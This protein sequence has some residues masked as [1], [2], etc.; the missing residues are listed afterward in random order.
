MTAFRPVSE[1][2][3]SW[4][5]DNVDLIIEMIQHFMWD[6]DE[7]HGRVI[8]ILVPF[9]PYKCPQQWH[10]CINGCSASITVLRET[11]CVNIINKRKIMMTMTLCKLSQRARNTRLPS[12]F[13]A[14]HCHAIGTVVRV[15]LIFANI[16]TYRG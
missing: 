15:H 11:F 2:A 6:A 12:V 13:G 4:S 9:G 8:I 7:R 14:M 16:F 3:H 1:A 5:Y 10:I